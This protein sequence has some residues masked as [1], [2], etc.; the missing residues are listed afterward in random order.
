[1]DK[2]LEFLAFKFAK[3]NFKLLTQAFCCLTLNRFGVII[4][5]LEKFQAF[6][7]KISSKS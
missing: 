1:V 5:I 7:I 6:K 4:E 2:K 3:V